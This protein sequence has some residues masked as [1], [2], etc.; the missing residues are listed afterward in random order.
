MAYIIAGEEIKKTLLRYDP[1]K[2]ELFHWKSARLADKTL[3]QTGFMGNF[4]FIRFHKRGI[5][6][7]KP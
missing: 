3:D 7:I 4:K 1:G 2:S 6:C 5:N